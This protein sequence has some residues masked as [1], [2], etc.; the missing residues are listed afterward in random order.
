MQFRIP[1]GL[2][3]YTDTY[4]VARSPTKT[5]FKYPVSGD[6]HSGL[7]KVAMTS[8]F[9]HH[10]NQWRRQYEHPTVQVL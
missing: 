7:S 6:G 4:Y 2:K 5:D 3:S 1:V 9:P 8:H 10:G